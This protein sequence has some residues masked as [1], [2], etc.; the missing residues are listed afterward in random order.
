MPLVFLLRAGA[1]PRRGMS[2]FTGWAKSLPDPP[3]AAAPQQAIWPSCFYISDLDQR[4]SSAAK[5]RRRQGLAWLLALLRGLALRTPLSR[6]RRRGSRCRRLCV[7]NGLGAAF[8]VDQP[9]VVDRMLYRVQAGAG[10]E[11]PAGKDASHL[12]LQ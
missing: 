2:R 9:D 10:R 11:H 1:M 3:K 5:A 8:A 4:P 7:H 6:R 12:A